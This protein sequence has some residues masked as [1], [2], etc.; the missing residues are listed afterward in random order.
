MG[1]KLYMKIFIKLNKIF[2][3]GIEV[4]FRPQANCEKEFDK[5]LKISDE[6]VLKS[7]WVKTGNDIKKAITIYGK[8]QSDKKKF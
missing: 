5:I 7:D 3:S 4:F 8:K 6:E 2:L 1:A